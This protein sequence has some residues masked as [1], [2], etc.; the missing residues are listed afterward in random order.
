MSMDHHGKSEK[1]KH[2]GT[3]LHS[4]AEQRIENLYKKKP[5][6]FSANLE[7]QP[8]TN[9]KH[10]SHK[11]VEEMVKIAYDGETDGGLSHHKKKEDSLNLGD[12][13]TNGSSGAMCGSMMVVR[14]CMVLS[15]VAY[16][17]I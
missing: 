6:V 10:L 4:L 8:D 16:Y 15:A 11:E 5:D 7:A 2:S 13:R 17:A 12:G 3:D 1:K 9:T 14:L